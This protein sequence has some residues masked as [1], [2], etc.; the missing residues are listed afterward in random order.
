MGCG[1]QCCGFDPE[2]LFSDPNPTCRFFRVFYF[3]SFQ[4]R[5]YPG[6]KC[7][8]P[9]H[10]LFTD[11]TGSVSGSGSQH[12]VVEVWRCFLLSIPAYLTLRW[13]TS[14]SRRELITLK[15]I[16][17]KNIPKISLQK[18]LLEENV[19]AGIEESARREPGTPLPLPLRREQHWEAHHAKPHR[20][21]HRWEPSDYRIRVT[22]FSDPASMRTDTFSSPL[23]NSQ[24]RIRV[25]FGRIQIRRLIS[26][27]TGTGIQIL[28]RILPFR[29]QS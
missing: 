12:R 24:Y 22:F 15:P 17:P 27:R 26:M 11:P 5:S 10:A 8:V 21:C 9:D 2:W 28:I 16:N 23:L 13:G 29:L 20:P 1:A 19:R 25:T 18:K 14:V 4:I 3:N 7:F 6:L